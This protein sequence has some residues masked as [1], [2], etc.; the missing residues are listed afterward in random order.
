M[1]IRV[2]PAAFSHQSTSRARAPLTFPNRTASSSAVANRGSCSRTTSGGAAP[3]AASCA[4]SHSAAFVVVVVNMMRSGTADGSLEASGLYTTRPTSRL[5][6]LQQTNHLRLK[7]RSQPH[8]KP[9]AQRPSTTPF[10]APW[11][12][13]PVSRGSSPPPVWPPRCSG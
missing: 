11:K 8:S 12:R 9:T 10:N 3:D 2:S 13:D 4:W 6:N 7:R 1:N 5:K